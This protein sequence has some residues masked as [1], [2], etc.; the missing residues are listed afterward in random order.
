MDEIS[1]LKHLIFCFNL[2]YVFPVFDSSTKLQTGIF[3]GNLMEFGAFKQCIN[4]YYNSKYGPI[5]GKQCTLKIT[6]TLNIVKKIVAFRNISDKVNIY[7]KFLFSNEK[8]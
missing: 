3:N 1:F 4:I 6:P 5:R 8:V 7:T 2:V